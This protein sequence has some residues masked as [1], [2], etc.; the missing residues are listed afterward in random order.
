[1]KELILHIQQWNGLLLKD[2]FLFIE[3]YGSFRATYYIEN[4]RTS[5]SLTLIAAGDASGNTDDKYIPVDNLTSISPNGNTL[6]QVNTGSSTQYIY[7]GSDENVIT[8]IKY[9]GETYYKRGY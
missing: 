5:P 8:A 2:S 6:T 7:I 9:N 4:I 1:M 3:L